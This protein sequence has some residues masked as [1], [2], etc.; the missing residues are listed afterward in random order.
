MGY[1]SKKRN[2]ITHCKIFGCSVG[3]NNK[4]C[5]CR[6]FCKTHY[7]RYRT[8][9]I[10]LD[11]NP[12]RVP[13]RETLKTIERREKRLELLAAHKTPYLVKKGIELLTNRDLKKLL[14]PKDN[15]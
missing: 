9:L 5:W 10:T 7:N 3:P 8:G 6:G 11:G 4:G 1:I 2:N 12:T 13:S 15:K 14:K